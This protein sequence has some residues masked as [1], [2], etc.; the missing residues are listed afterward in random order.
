METGKSVLCIDPESKLAYRYSLTTEEYSLEHLSPTASAKV[1]EDLI[2]VETLRA[3]ELCEWEFASEACEMYRRRKLR[4]AILVKSASKFPV[5]T[6]NKQLSSALS[7][8][9]AISL[10]IDISAYFQSGLLLPCSDSLRLLS[11]PWRLEL[12]IS[13]LRSAVEVLQ[14]TVDS[15]VR[16]GVEGKT[17]YQENEFALKVSGKR[18]FVR[19]NFPMLA[20]EGIRKL[21]RETDQIPLKL[22]EIPKEKHDFFPPIIEESA[23]IPAEFSHSFFWYAPESLRNEGKLRGKAAG[24][25]LHLPRIHELTRERQIKS[26]G[27]LLTGENVEI[28]ELVT[29]ECDF[30][31]RVCLK[32]CERLNKLFLEGIW[33]RATHAGLCPPSCL[34]LPHATKEKQQDSAT[35]V[36]PTNS[37]ESVASLLS[38][39]SI[40]GGVSRRTKLFSNLSHWGASRAAQF[41]GL[42]KLPGPMKYLQFEVMLVYGDKV[43]RYRERDCV[44]RSAK[45]NFAF[46]VRLEEWINFHIPLSRLPKEV[47]LCIN[48]HAYTPQ[49]AFTIGSAAITLYDEFGQ[50]RT[51]PQCLN[52]WPFYRVEPRLSCMNNYSGTTGYIVPKQYSQTGDLEEGCM[53]KGYG[54][55]VVE[56][57]EFL[58]DKNE[59]SLR[60]G[61]YMQQWKEY[62]EK[63]I[64]NSMESTSISPLYGTNRQPLL[65][66][67]TPS[68]SSTPVPVSPLTTKPT[69]AQ[70]ASLE[71]LVE[72]DSLDELETEEKTLLLCCRDHYKTLPLALPLFLR[73][74]DWMEPEMVKEALRMMRVWTPMSA[75]DALCLL[76]A[77]FPD[78]AIRFYSI[79]LLSSISDDQLALFMPQLIQALQSECHHLSHLSEFLL[80]RALRNPFVVGHELFWTLRSQLHF[81]PAGERFG[82][83]LE[84]FVL[85]CGGYREELL[86]EVRMIAWL[87]A[88]GE[89]VKKPEGQEAKKKYLCE[90]LAAE[91]ADFAFPW[92]LCFDSRLQC[93]G[94]SSTGS[95][96]SSAKKPLLLTFQ[97]A[98]SSHPDLRIIFK[99]GDDMRQDILTIQLIRVM[100]SIWLENGLDLRMLTY[101][102]A[103]T[104]DQVG[105][106]EFVPDSSTTKQVSMDEGRG[107]LGT[108]GKKTIVTYLRKHS[109][110][111]EIA[112]SRSVDNFIRSCAGYSVATYILGIGDRHND[113]IMLTKKGQLF[114]ID[115][116]HFLGNFKSV[117]GINRERS[118]FVLT[119]EMAYVMKKV[120]NE[121][122][123]SAEF[124]CYVQYCGQAYNLIRRVGRRFIYL[125]QLMIGAGIPELTSKASIQYMR[126]KLALRLTER[127]AEER[128]RREIDKALSNYYR[129]VDN[130]I[131]AIKHGD[132]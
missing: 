103:A 130:M 25:R 131:H 48:L 61:D 9:A 59:W 43:V 123:Q 97:N 27:N 31:L 29:G 120:A 2:T 116:G 17:H 87:K 70:I 19:G 129:K 12:H 53:E 88:L 99:V 11:S 91:G 65:P 95:V 38:E 54:Q 108:L 81:K 83:I 1:A 55:I 115:Y 93:K 127:Q 84:Q 13:P 85:L 98:E 57:E 77:E 51:G 128:F 7:D 109:G 28:A 49:E 94:V 121:E 52:I 32:G 110:S 107:A 79:R 112:Y 10:L 66:S 33:G 6:T 122:H 90:R 50:L 41:A 82:V 106:V 4:T 35:K 117:A 62:I 80:E 73:A 5:F 30:P 111:D 126:E 114:H 34:V 24:K 20:F 119:E 14:E 3:F 40:E 96:M 104:H 72:K 39:R 71:E 78:E 60:D 105:M 42:F 89:G 113:N 68:Q 101:R 56:L 37:N 15:L 58:T 75:E 118:A 18:E 46:N 21:L 26:F 76:D 67:K 86:A 22:M 125:F 92:T 102:V 63:P 44:M 23:A 16:L 74:V 100:D 8:K 69:I 36:T 45:V 47:R 124:R 64:Q 132:K